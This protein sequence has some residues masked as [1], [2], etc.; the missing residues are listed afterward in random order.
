MARKIRPII[1][2]ALALTVCLTFIISQPPSVRAAAYKLASGCYD[3][4][5][6]DQQINSTCQGTQVDELDTN[7]YSVTDP[8]RLIGVAKWFYSWGCIAAWIGFRN[9]SGDTLTQ[10]EVWIVRNSDHTVSLVNYDSSLPN[11]QWISSRMLGAD[12]P[13]DGSTGLDYYVCFE[14]IGGTHWTCVD[15]I[16]QSTFYPPE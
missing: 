13:N 12:Y 16:P 6:D 2:V 8:G 10:V 9:E 7:I 4:G 1:I 11:K 3:R 5:C 14:D 15:S